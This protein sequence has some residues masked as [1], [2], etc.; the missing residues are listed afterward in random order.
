MRKHKL[1][2]SLEGHQKLRTPKNCAT[3]SLGKSKVLGNAADR[4][5]FD[6]KVVASKG[7][8]NTPKVIQGVKQ[9]QLSNGFKGI[10]AMLNVMIG[11]ID[12]FCLSLVP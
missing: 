6:K 12:R 2:E 1:R 5:N 3:S 4:Q 11:Y 9:A 10:F 7:L 8:V